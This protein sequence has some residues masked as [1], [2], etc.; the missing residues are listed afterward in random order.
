MGAV[1]ESA[2]IERLLQGALNTMMP[3]GSLRTLHTQQYSTLKHLISYIMRTNIQRILCSYSF[4]NHI[5]ASSKAP[6]SIV[7]CSLKREISSLAVSRLQTN[8]L[9]LR[10]TLTLALS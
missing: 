6:R 5:R 1:S 9:I 3:Y 4:A 7:A 10:A 8:H 2:Q